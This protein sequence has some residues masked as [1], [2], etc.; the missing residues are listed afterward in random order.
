MIIS[1]WQDLYLRTAVL[2]SCVWSS[3]W[4]VS[5]GKLN[6]YIHQRSADVPLGLPFNVSQYAILLYI[7]AKLSGLE[8]GNLNWSIMDA[9]IYVNQIDGINKQL[10]R[11]DL[12]KKDE[13][14]IQTE[15][16]CSINEYL[17]SIN[18]KYSAC[19]EANINNNGKFQSDFDKLK[20]E[21]K[22]I[23]LMVTKE[24]PEIV[25]ANRDNFFEYSNSFNNNKEYLK[26]N[27]TGNED[28]KILKYSSGPH[29]KLP[30]AQ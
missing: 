16:L 20:D 1:L 4:K 18:K 6:A 22:I 19:E 11:F 14:I 25:L 2:P 23:E 8:P 10:D 30:I 12:M 5:G 28:I 24:K 15:N 3:E 17:E 27:K 21:K 9:H 26:S 13:K 7:F 29:I